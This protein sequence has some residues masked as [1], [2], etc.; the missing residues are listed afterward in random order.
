MLKYVIISSVFSFFLLNS[1]VINGV[2]PTISS[3]IGMGGQ[4]N[5]SQ[6]ES[7]V[8]SAV[9][10][11][12]S[13]LLQ[14]TSSSPQNTNNN[15]NTSDNNNSLSSQNNGNTQIVHNTIVVEPKAEIARSSVNAPRENTSRSS[16]LAV[17]DEP[18]IPDSYR[19]I[20][21]SL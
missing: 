8:K 18:D 19:Y 15:L 2:I 6:R 12:S 7:P 13:G 14:G 3:D 9:A 21:Q 17:C 16:G 4:S 20:C 1:C 10:D 11:S 5:S